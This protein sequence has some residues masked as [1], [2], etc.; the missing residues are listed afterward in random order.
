MD[1]K[2][3]PDCQDTGRTA[4][5]GN[6]GVTIVSRATAPAFTGG[7][8]VGCADVNGDGVPDILT[9]PGA[10]GGPHVRVFSGV[11]GSELMGFLAYPPAFTG[12]L[13]I[14]P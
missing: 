11:D 2:P 5:R 14:A 9:A 7:V 8:T 12:G 3:G 13:F 1:T 6:R 4:R 10:G